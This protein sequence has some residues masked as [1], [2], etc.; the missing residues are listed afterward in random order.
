MLTREQSDLIDRQQIRA[1]KIVYGFN[2][3]SE[4]VMQKSG[5]EHLSVRRRDAVDR[6]A[7]KLTVNHRYMFPLR[8]ES[9]VVP[10]CRT[11]ILNSTPEPQGYI[12]FFYMLGRLNQ[13]ALEQ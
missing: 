6:F 9:H 5:L 11:D 2:I 1:L 12:T 10:G 7:Q 13:L 8:Q 3:S 4:Q